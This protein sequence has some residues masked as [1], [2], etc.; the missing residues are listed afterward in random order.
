[1]MC[2]FVRCAAIAAVALVSACGGGSQPQTQP[3][4][5]G[6]VVTEEY[7]IDA[8]DDGVKLFIRNKHPADY[9]DYRPERTVLF[10]HGATF[11][12]HSTFDL[13]LDGT[14][15]MDWM[16]RRGY[17]VY[18][19]DLRGYG[20][21]T[22][23]DSMAKPADQN[24]P[25]VDGV[26]ALR[27]VS[28]AVDFITSRRNLHRLVLVGWSWG[29]TLAGTYV[30]NSGDRVERLVL[31]APQ[32]L[33]DQPPMADLTLGAW[34]GVRVEQAQERWLRD[35][36]QNER[37]DLVP[38]GW[39]KTWAEAQR[40]S[41]PDGARMDPPVLRAPNGVV[42]DA[43]KTWAAGAP[44]WMPEKVSIP[45]LVVQGE[46]DVDN[47]PSMGLGV[48]S[49]LVRAPNRRF[50]LI[51]EGTHMLML[52]KNREQLFRAVQSFLEERL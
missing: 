36:P 51:G 16:A 24:P 42:A 35:V 13:A 38:A 6:G 27:D 5:Q 21:S 40:A 22:R 46:W 26:A 1:M 8:K 44:A 23:P 47:P 19:L 14:S 2:R 49:R 4:T 10:V 3:T 9:H 34:R 41:D 7:L 17:D 29:G 37:G 32:W 18:A 50:L 12:G 25:A 48:F 15:W 31:L 45:T 30:T 20:K 52:E 43:L 33:R 28:K 11:A 39:L